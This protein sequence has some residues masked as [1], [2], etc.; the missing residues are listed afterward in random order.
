MKTSNKINELKG[1]NKPKCWFFEKINTIDQKEKLPK[2]LYQNQN[3][4]YHY[5][6]HDH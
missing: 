1:E 5:R 2:L 6:S 4:E 3:R